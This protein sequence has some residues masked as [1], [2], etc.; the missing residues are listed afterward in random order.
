[1]TPM[2]SC[3]AV[4]VSSLVARAAAASWPTMMPLISA[5]LDPGVAKVRLRFGSG[6][7]HPRVQPLNSAVPEVRHGDLGHVGAGL[8][9][10]GRRFLW[11]PVTAGAAARRAHDRLLEPFIMKVICIICGL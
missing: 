7:L 1:M 11:F 8:T 4:T 2:A 6:V 9:V 3:R 10:T 5:R